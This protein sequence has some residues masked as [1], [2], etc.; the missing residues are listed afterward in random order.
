M[1]KPLRY[2]VQYDNPELFAKAVAEAGGNPELTDPVDYVRDRSFASLSAARAFK[3]RHRGAVLYERVNI[4][5]VTPD[6]DP[7]GLLWDFDERLVED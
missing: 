2:F 3:A 1:K 7:Q 5:D 4:R 6:D